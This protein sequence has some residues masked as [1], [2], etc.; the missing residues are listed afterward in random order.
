MLLHPVGGVAAACEG[1]TVTLTCVTDTGILFWELDPQKSTSTE[2][3]FYITTSSINEA[4]VRLVS[5]DIF[6]KL[7]NVSGKVL[8][9]VATAIRVPSS[10]NGT[11][12][13]CSDNTTLE[14]GTESD[15]RTLLIKGNNHYSL[16]SNLDD[17]QLLMR[18]P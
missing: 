2:S 7:I 16:L 5:T 18:F 8:T 9:S 10:L 17:C 14:D 12:I 6:V 13:R 3:K 15:K 4:P 1:D 11:V